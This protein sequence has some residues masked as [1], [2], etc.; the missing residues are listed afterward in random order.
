MVA[1]IAY[2]GA[3]A[4]AGQAPSCHTAPTN[5]EYANEEPAACRPKPTGLIVEALAGG[6]AF[7]L[8]FMAWAWVLGPW[9]RPNEA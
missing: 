7:S 2:G 6:L 1:P 3:L 4:L 5:P 8:A 9:R